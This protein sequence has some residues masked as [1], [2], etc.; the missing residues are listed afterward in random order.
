M[1]R[2]DDFRADLELPRD[3]RKELYDFSGAYD[4]GHL[5]SSETLDG[6][7]EMNSETFLL[8]NMSPQLGGFNRAIWKGLENRERKWARM[9]GKLHVI[10]GPVFVAKVSKKMMGRIP[11]PT[12]FYKILFDP[13]KGQ[14]LS[15]LI[16]HRVLKTGSLGRFRMSIDQIEK[17]TGIDF[18]SGLEDEIEDRLESQI[19]AMW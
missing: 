14:A 11:V 6:N 4:R 10:T 18:F 13:T 12:H 19:S 1:E 7:R 17:V 2:S 16:P 5:V 3:C 9:N 8:S 15:F